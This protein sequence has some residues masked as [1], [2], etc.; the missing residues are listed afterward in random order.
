M[1]DPV[2][3]GVPRRSLPIR[4]ADTLNA[5]GGIS[6]S[7]NLAEGLDEVW[8][9][10]DGGLLEVNPATDEQRRVITL[11]STANP[12]ASAD[13]TVGGRFVWLGLGDGRL[14]RF[15]PRSG[16]EDTRTGL[17]AI[18]TIAFGHGAV[19][20]LDAVGGTVSAYDPATMRPSNQIPIS[21]ADNIVVGDE[22]LWVLSLSAGTLTRIDPSTNDAAGTVQVGPNPT[23][24]AAGGGAIWVGDED[25]VIRRVD[26]DTRQ[27]TEVPFGAEVRGIAYDDE[28]GTLWV[29][30]A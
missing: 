10:Y 8:V 17:D 22:G 23:A 18:D 12:L 30:V 26:E 3:I 9:A 5:P 24:I 1:D 21:G 2:D 13:V 15:D 27:V 16:R 14:I 4:G 25:G 11:G 29:D 6:F 7:A 20:T 28:A 19:W